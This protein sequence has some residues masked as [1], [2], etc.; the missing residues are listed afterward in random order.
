MIEFANLSRYRSELMGVA[1]IAIILFHIPLGRAD[2]FFG[3]HRLG[4]VVRQC[5]SRYGGISGRSKLFV[6]CGC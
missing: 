4:N 2:A 1:M 5:S 6:N 3:L